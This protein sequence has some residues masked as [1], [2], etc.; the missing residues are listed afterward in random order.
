MTWVAESIC[1]KISW[2]NRN[3]ATSFTQPGTDSGGLIITIEGALPPLVQLF[4]N[5]SLD[6]FNSQQSNGNN[7]ENRFIGNIYLTNTEFS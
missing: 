4:H 3:T 5:L 1:H 6:H 2:W 7:K